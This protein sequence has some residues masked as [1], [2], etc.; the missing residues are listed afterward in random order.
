MSKT[1]IN[2]QRWRLQQTI[3]MTIQIWNGPEDTFYIEN[4]HINYQYNVLSTKYLFLNVQN[5]CWLPYSWRN[6]LFSN[7]RYDVCLFLFLKICLFNILIK[8]WCHKKLVSLM[9]KEDEDLLVRRGSF[10]WFF[11]SF[12][13]VSLQ[14]FIS[15]WYILIYTS[16]TISLWPCIIFS[17]YTA[18][19][20][21]FAFRTSRSY[22]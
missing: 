4:K 2:Y 1:T 12:F 7:N 6:F 21:I 15:K 10:E 14:I 18:I 22:P 11:P 3:L 16:M 5:W 19:D 13:W 20:W 8:V 17:F 9:H